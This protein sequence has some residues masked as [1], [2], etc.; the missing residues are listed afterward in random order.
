MWL[1]MITIRIAI[2]K[3]RRLHVRWRRQSLS[4][5]RVW[6]RTKLMVTIVRRS[7]G[8]ISH[9]LMM[10]MLMSLRWWLLS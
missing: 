8:A 7:T 4:V 3:H 6:I 5:I 10:I 2:T 9:A 1:M